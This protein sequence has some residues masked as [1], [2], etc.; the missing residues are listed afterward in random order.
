MFVCVYVCFPHR[1]I[2]VISPSTFLQSNENE[3]TKTASA[4]A[5]RARECVLESRS[6]SLPGMMGGE[7]EREAAP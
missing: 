1:R 3:R 2:K 5:G 7:R 6:K 4:T